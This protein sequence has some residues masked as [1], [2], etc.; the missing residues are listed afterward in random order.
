LANFAAEISTMTIIRVT[1]KFRFEAAHALTGYDG[2]C[3][4]I[5]GHSYELSVTV[6]GTPVANELSPKK[7]MVIDFS[8][9]KDIVKKNVVE[10]FDHSLILKKDYTVN[11]LY[12]LKEPFGNVVFVDYQPTSE[13]LLIDFAQ[14]IRE[15]LPPHILLHSLRLKET[16]NSFAEWFAVD[17]E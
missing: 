6:S 3:R 12:D 15:A 16:A 8:D 17:N 2:L 10:M 14:R 13:N 5:H 1:K 9:I 4:N 11:S 7:G